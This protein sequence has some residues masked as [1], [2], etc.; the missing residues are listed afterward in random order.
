MTACSPPWKLSWLTGVT[1]NSARLTV[2]RESWPSCAGRHR[3][4]RRGKTG[5]GSSNEAWSTWAALPL[6]TADPGHPS[7]TIRPSR[8]GSSTRK[9]RRT[10]HLVTSTSTGQILAANS[11]LEMFDLLTQPID[12]QPAPT[13]GHFFVVQSRRAVTAPVGECVPDTQSSATW[14]PTR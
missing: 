12:P 6:W 10:G 3:T 14:P 13:A 11:M 7:A 9:R 2:G 4:E 1:A 8:Q 5:S